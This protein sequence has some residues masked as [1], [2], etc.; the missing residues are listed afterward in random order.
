MQTVTTSFT[1]YP[2]NNNVDLPVAALLCLGQY[3]LKISPDDPLLHRMTLVPLILLS[4]SDSVLFLAVIHL[5]SC[6]L[7]AISK[8]NNFVKACNCSFE[9]Y[10]NMFCRDNDS[11][12]VVNKMEKSAGIS[13]KV[14]F[15]FAISSLLMKGLTISATREKTA[16]MCATLVRL[17]TGSQIQ[18]AS[19]MLGYLAALIPNN[20]IETVAKY[21]PLVANNAPL[22]LQENDHDNTIDSVDS[23]QPSTPIVATPMVEAQ[24]LA[25]SSGEEGKTGDASSHTGE[26]IFYMEETYNNPNN[27]LL[28]VRYLLTV[29]QNMEF[30][31]DKISIYSVLQQ[32]F[33]KLTKV[34]VPV[35]SHV[36]PRVI[37]VYNH[38]SSTRIAE[39]SLSL[40]T[41][42]MAM[43]SDT[44]MNISQD[45]DALKEIGFI[46]LS[47][48]G[49]FKAVADKQRGESLQ[50]MLDLMKTISLN[51]PEVSIPTLPPQSLEKNETKKMD[52]KEDKKA[53]LQRQQSSVFEDQHHT[54]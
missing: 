22:N 20:Y 32:A 30:D 54:V 52:Q 50:I 27:A 4:A 38:A 45:K 48:S 9:Q 34:F 41:T 25:S 51:L 21:L 28:F 40:I 6:V 44:V 46:G 19:E 36:M 18:N 15:S 5:L 39:L 24:H 13:F 7:K 49:S 10:F 35:F 14:N 43:D 31:N 11:D 16:H 1:D 23:I 33:L 42:M 29:V 2:Q 12:D 17:S 53:S 8:S 3:C 26:T 37:S 47:R